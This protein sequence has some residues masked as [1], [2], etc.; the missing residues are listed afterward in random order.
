MRN[1]DKF[2]G[3]D[4][5][6]DILSMVQEK[7]SGR[8]WP[9]GPNE[10]PLVLNAMSIGILSARLQLSLYPAAVSARD[11]AEELVR[12]HLRM[13]YSVHHDLHTIMTGSSPEPL[14]AEASALIMNYVLESRKPYMELWTL[15]WQYIDH[16][17]AAQGAIGELI[18]RALSISAMDRAI[19]SLVSKQDNPNCELLYQTPVTVTDYYKA[20]L[21]KDAWE[22]LRHTLPANYVQLDTAVAE[23]TFEKAFEKGYFHFSHYGQAN[24]ISPLQSQ[25]AWAYWLRGTAIACQLNQELTD[26]MTPIYFPDQGPVSPRS[27]SVNLDQ[28]KTSQSV[29]PPNVSIQSAEHLSIFPDGTKL[30]YIAAVHCYAL[31]DSDMGIKPEPGPSERLQ[32]TR[33]LRSSLGNSE[34]PRYQINFYGLNAY[35]GIA[36]EERAIIRRMIDRSK[37]ALFANHP[38]EYGVPSVRQMLPLLSRDPD[39]MKWIAGSNQDTASGRVNPGTSLKRALPATATSSSTAVPTSAAGSRGQKRK[40]MSGSQV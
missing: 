1:L 37:D 25:Y 13:L 34:A 12:N 16:G 10:D 11:Y 27:I 36:E 2:P 35:D 28:D 8:S 19:N 5:K 33:K 21:T 3:R 17:L 14:V 38:R 6:N 32:Q 24:D 22:E 40:K 15:L 23:I 39:A 18:G 26:R 7:L 4:I 30:P 29:S 20:L 31:T 9:P